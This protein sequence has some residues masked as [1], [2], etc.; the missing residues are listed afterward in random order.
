MGGESPLAQA[1]WGVGWELC[2]VVVGGVMVWGLLIVEAV[3]GWSPVSVG[4]GTLDFEGAETVSFWGAVI[5]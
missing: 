5:D 1:P 3:R 4:G 2:P